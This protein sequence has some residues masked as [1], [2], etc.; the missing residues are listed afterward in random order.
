MCRDD[1]ATLRQPYS[2]LVF[3]IYCSNLFIFDLYHIAFGLSILQSFPVIP[4][5]IAV[6]FGRSSTFCT[7]RKP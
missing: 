3:K 6:D 2:Q 7:G 1:D 4:S 5:L